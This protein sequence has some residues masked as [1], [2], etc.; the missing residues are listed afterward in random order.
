MDRAIPQQVPYDFKEVPSYTLAEARKHGWI[1]R[2]PIGNRFGTGYVYS[3]RFTTDEEAREDYNE[4]LQENFNVSL[5]TDRIINYKPGYYKD[6]W[7]GNCMAVGLSS[8]FV[9]PLESTGLHIIIQQMLNFIEHNP[10]LKN[11]SY[12][13]MESNRLNRVLYDEIIEFICLHYNTNRTDSKFWQYMTEN[14]SEWV[15]MFDEKCREEFLQSSNIS[16]TKVFWNIESYIQV[17]NGLQ[18]FNPDSIKEY[19]S[20]LENSEDILD[21]CRLL[22]MEIKKAK[23]LNS[24]V[25]QKDMFKFLHQ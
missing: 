3:S 13:R 2:I 16:G 15:R 22:D 12:N 24:N 23:E 5:E 9:E 7:I 25:P 21:D 6:N 20:S 14:K 8:G 17:A 4:W 10:T 1:W 19:V 11:L 18:M